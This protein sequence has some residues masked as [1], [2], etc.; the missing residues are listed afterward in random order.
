MARIRTRKMKWTD[1]TATDLVSVEI[2]AEKGDAS[3]NADFLARIE[4]DKVTPHAVVAKGVQ[5]YF[6][7]NLDEATYNLAIAG[8]DDDGNHSNVAQDPSWVAAPLDITPP[9]APV[10]SPLE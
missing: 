4:A 2:Y 6:L 5:S 7:A 3:T 1:P 10:P 8:L 9:D